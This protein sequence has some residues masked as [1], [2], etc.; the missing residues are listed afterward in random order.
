LVAA[1]RDGEQE[2]FMDRIGTPQP[3]E[4]TLG[5]TVLDRPRHQHA[6]LVPGPTRIGAGA[7]V[8]D[9]P[10]SGGAEANTRLTGTVGLVLLLLFA[11][12]IA[13]VILGV[14]SVL[15]WHVVIGLILVPPVLLKIGST[16]WRMVSYYRRTGD[17]R[18]HPRPSSAKRILGPLLAALT[19][20]MGASGI[21][22]VVLPRW[23]HAAALSVHVWA[24]YAWLAALLVHVVPHFVHAL[25]VAGRDWSGK[26]GSRIPRGGRRRV[27]VAVSLALGAVLALLLVGR[28]TGYLHV[29]PPK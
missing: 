29:Y 2:K 4:I 18:Q 16:T 25:R 12:Q 14:R 9:V 28:A 11:A 27:A 15:A 10:A 22:L 20:T 19:V 26:V 23:A 8:A 13:T 21:V 7:L 6:D 1:S 24:A 5:A 17:Y 3:P